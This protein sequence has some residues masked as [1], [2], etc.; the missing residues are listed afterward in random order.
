MLKYY[1]ES[2]VFDRSFLDA[3]FENIDAGPS[4]FELVC[5]LPLS[6]GALSVAS[7]MILSD[8]FKS[9]YF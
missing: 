1:G 3:F 5:L 8:E 6:N 2:N 7:Q 9:S 4:L